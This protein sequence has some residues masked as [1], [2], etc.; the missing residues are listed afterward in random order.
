VKYIIDR[1]QFVDE[2]KHEPVSCIGN[3][4]IE[5]AVSFRGYKNVLIWAVEYNASNSCYTPKPHFSGLW[6]A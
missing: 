2:N 4:R 5:K 1:S 6:V 3:S